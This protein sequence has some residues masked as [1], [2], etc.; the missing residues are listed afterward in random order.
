VKPVIIIAGATSAFSSPLL[1]LCEDRFEI[2][3]A[4]SVEEALRLLDREPVDLVFADV[5]LPGGGGVALT[6]AG[7]CL[8]SG[9]EVLVCSAGSPPPTALSDALERAVERARRRREVRARPV[10][11]EEYVKNAT[12]EAARRYLVAL[13]DRFRGN[14]SRAAREAEIERAS[15]HRLLRRHGINAGEFRQRRGDSKERA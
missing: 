1:T 3:A 7:K 15:F 13:L 6:D 10:A 11:Y 4:A 12:A 2:M 9:A 5:A 8:A 14:V